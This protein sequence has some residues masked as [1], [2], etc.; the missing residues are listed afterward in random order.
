MT[1]EQFETFTSLDCERRAF[2]LSYLAEHGVK[3]VTLDLDGRHHIY[4]KFPLHQYNPQFRMKTVIAHYDR[5]QGTPGANDNSAAAALLLDW[6]DKINRLPYFH[7]VRLILTDGEEADIPLMHEA[8]NV[9]CSAKQGVT[10]QGSFSLAAVFRRLGITA[11]DVYVFDCVGR[12]TIP[13]LA[14][15]DAISAPPA[16]RRALVSLE[17]RAKELFQKASM[18]YICLPV[19]YSDNAGFVAQGIPAVCITMLPEAEANEYLSS[20]MKEKPLSHF[21]LNRANA[22]I[23]E[24]NKYSPLLPHTWQLFHTMEDNFQS[25]TPQSIPVMERILTAL[26]NARQV[27]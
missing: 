8:G 25:L 15:N 9:E 1:K 2:I 3:A 10:K 6:A 16:F 18:G 13:I 20:L 17:E 14:R 24:A 12:G 11:E 27:R 19:P 7:N 21:V 5:A 4:I 26:Q 22:S 23:E